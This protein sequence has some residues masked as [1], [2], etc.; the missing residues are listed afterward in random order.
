MSAAASKEE[1]AKYT[2]MHDIRQPIPHDII[3]DQRRAESEL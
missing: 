2:K 1:T 3:R